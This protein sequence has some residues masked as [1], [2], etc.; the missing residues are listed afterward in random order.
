M[1]GPVV[2][3]AHRTSTRKPTP[4]HIDEEFAVA[5]LAASVL[6]EYFPI[7]LDYRDGMTSSA[8]SAPEQTPSAA[9]ERPLLPG[10]TFGVL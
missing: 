1:A 5:T 6:G 2:E 10:A 4:G 7:I 9:L 8:R 3:A